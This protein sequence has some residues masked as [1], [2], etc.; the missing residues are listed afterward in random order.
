MTIKRTA[1]LALVA[2]ALSIQPSLT[3]DGIDEDGRLLDDPR[4]LREVVAAWEWLSDATPVEVLLPRASTSILAELAAE[5]AG[6]TEV[7]SGAML[8]A[9]IG[10]GIAWER[11]GNGPHA[12]LAVRPGPGWTSP[13]PGHVAAAVRRLGNLGADDVVGSLV[14]TACAFRG[15]Q[16][17][18]RNI[19]LAITLA[20]SQGLIF[21]SLDGQLALA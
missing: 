11:V 4:A 8:A 7:G 12:L 1:A 15:R 21:R 13:A 20:L 2:A 16:P 6:L 17:P 19:R 10:L 18:T 9:A 14:A 3:A 5:R